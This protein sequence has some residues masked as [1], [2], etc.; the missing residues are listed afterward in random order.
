M[1]RKFEKWT[2]IAR[3]NPVLENERRFLSPKERQEIEGLLIEGK[4]VKDV[5]K[6]Y[7]TGEDALWK[8]RRKLD[9][10][11]AKKTLAQIAQIKEML[12]RGAVQR[13]IMLSVGCGYKMI[14]KARESEEEKR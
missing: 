8:I 7:G 12:K 3:S 10:G 11:R 1:R 13:E 2:E 9:G 6:K 4:T 5:A 14:R